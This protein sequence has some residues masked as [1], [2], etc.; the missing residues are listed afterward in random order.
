[1]LLF[2]ADVALTA[3]RENINPLFVKVIIAANVAW[4]VG[5][6]IALLFYSGSLTVEGQW[7]VEIIA[8]AVAVLAGLQAVGLKRLGG[9]SARTA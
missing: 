8:I 7:V 2:A 3:T 4:V 5:S 1:M 9:Q 6:G